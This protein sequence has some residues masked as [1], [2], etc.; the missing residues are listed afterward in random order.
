[1]AGFPMKERQ[2]IIDG[3]LAATG[4]NM[5]VPAEFVDWLADQPHNPAY[6]LFYGMD[7]ATAAREHRISLARNMA[8]G[9]RITARVQ[10]ASPKGKPVTVSIREFPAMVSPVEGR[11]SGG[12]YVNF[13][14]DDAALAAELRRQG[15]QALRAWLAR[16]R[17]IAEAGGLD[18]CAI[19]EIAG[20]LD[21]TGV[22]VAA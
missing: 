19:E 4:R 1:M 9:L 22:V 2:A 3:Y 15:A 6:P 11:K 21:G 14:P 20:R 16:Y 10:E 13:D 5:F 7:D 18:V 12:G 17:G 8:A